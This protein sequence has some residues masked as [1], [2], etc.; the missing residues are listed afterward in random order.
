MTKNIRR[1]ICFA[2]FSVLIFSGLVSGCS[3]DFNQGAVATPTVEDNQSFVTATLPPQPKQD[4]ETSAFPSSSVPVTWSNLNLS[5]R[6][7][8]SS[9]H[10][11]GNSALMDIRVLDLAT[12]NITVIFQAPPSAWIYFLTVSPDGKQ[13]IMAYTLPPG[14]DGSSHQ[15]L[16]IL[17]V[18]GSAPPHLLFVPPTNDDEYIQPDWSPDGKY[19]YFSHVNYKAAPIQP[20]AHYPLFE[21]YRMAYPDGKPE[22]LIE[23]AFWPR[24]SDDT[25]RLAYVSLDPMTGKNK[26]FIA[27]ADGSNPV[28]LITSGQVIPD[29]ID[30]PAFS[31]NGQALLFSAPIPVQSYVPPATTWLEKLL[32]ISV[33]SAHTVPSEWWSVPLSGGAATQVTHIQATGL[34]AS[35][36]PDKKHIASYSGSGLF[37]MNQDGTGLTMLI[38]DLGGMPGTVNWIP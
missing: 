31:P 9:S 5:G 13:I 18:D 21:I 19:I 12:G 16:Y 7:I 29:I 28:T 15:E 38:S 25:S 8:Y 4:S 33:A 27:N 3:I 23:Q 22:K 10:Q 1:K 20:G 30:A 35:V 34:F 17:P 32:G 26:L 6:L 14:A 24:I 2:V 36:S 37:V 11:E